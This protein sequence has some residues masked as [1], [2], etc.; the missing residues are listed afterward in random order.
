MLIDDVVCKLNAKLKVAGLFL[1][2]RCAFDTVEHCSLLNKLDFYGIRGNVL[3]LFR[4]YLH[5]RTQYV[6][7]KTVQ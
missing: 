1:D 7:I 5:N 2:L 6:E 3:N 4:S